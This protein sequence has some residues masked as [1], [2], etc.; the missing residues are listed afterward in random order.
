[1]HPFLLLVALLHFGISKKG[2]A[3]KSGPHWRGYVERSEFFIGD[4]LDW[5]VVFLRSRQHKRWLRF[6][7]EW[8]LAKSGSKSLSGSVINQR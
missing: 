3:Q 8:R 7:L 6:V 4:R 5:R 1:M 2:L